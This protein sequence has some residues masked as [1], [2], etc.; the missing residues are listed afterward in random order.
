MV[1]LKATSVTATDELRA[2]LEP[3]TD[4][5]LIEARGRVAVRAWLAAPDA[6]MS[7]VLGSLG[8]ACG[9]SI[10]MTSS[11]SDRPS[12]L[13][14]TAFDTISSVVA[15][16]RCRAACTERACASPCP[17]RAPW[18]VASKSR[19]SDTL[20]FNKRLD[21][22]ETNCMVLPWTRTRAIP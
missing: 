2:E 22:Y 6:A 7:P 18:G 17:P 8:P 20:L 3:L 14:C 13:N 9:S 5:E 4:H 11:T 19:W 16:A 12:S 15:S 21:L 1:T 10:S